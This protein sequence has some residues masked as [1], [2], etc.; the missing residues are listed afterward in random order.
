MEKKEK[1]EEKEKEFSQSRRTT[2]I[3]G[4]RVRIW[5]AKGKGEGGK[6]QTSGLTNLVGRF[7]LH[8]PPTAAPDQAH[9]G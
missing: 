3:S 8:R 5:A 2:G 9:R 7:P 1:Q 6:C 4:K